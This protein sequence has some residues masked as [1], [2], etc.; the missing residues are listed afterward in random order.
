MMGYIIIGCLALL[1]GCAGVFNKML[2]LEA[3]RQLGTWNGTLVNYVESTII[4]GV[5]MILLGSCHLFQFSYLQTI[6][7]WYLFGGLFGVVSMLLALNGFAKSSIMTATVLM[8]IGQLS[9]GYLIDSIV[10]QK[11]DFFQL[12]GVLFVVVGVILDKK[13]AK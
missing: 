9:A 10:N 1:S 3:K 5:L 13:L 11:I 7:V 8:L 4:S 6:P 2:N 12:L